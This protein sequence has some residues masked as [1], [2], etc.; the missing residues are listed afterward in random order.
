MPDWSAL[1]A[2]A[3]TG[4]FNLIGS[5]LAGLFSASEARKQRKFQER[6]FKNRYR[7]TMSDMQ[8]AGLNPILA[9]GQGPGSAPGGAMGTMPSAS[10]DP[11]GVYTSAATAKEVRKDLKQSQGLKNA[12]RLMTIAQRDA[13]LAQGQYTDSLKVK[14]ELDNRLKSEEVEFLMSPKG[15]KYLENMFRGEA[16]GGGILGATGAGLGQAWD[17]WS[18]DVWNWMKKQAVSERDRLLEELKRRGKK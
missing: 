3:A 17:A 4:G 12:Q 10:A 15:R 14:Q 1:G 2:A 8:A 5:G 11:G 16:M 13:A 9:A 18:A 6:M 7:Y